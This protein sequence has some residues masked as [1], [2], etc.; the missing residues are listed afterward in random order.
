M[1]AKN[2]ALGLAGVGALAAFGFLKWKI[3]SGNGKWWALAI[4]GLLFAATTPSAAQ[5][6]TQ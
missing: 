5:G 2:I 4:G 1:T 3:L 6:E